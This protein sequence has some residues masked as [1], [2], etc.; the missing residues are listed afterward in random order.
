MQQS[1]S[2][3]LALLSVNLL[4]WHQSIHARHALRREG[5]AHW[6]RQLPLCMHK[7]D[8]LTCNGTF[9]SLATKEAW[10]CD[11]LSPIFFFSFASS[12]STAEALMMALSD[13]DE[14]GGGGRGEEGV[15]GLYCVWVCDLD[16]PSFLTSLPLLL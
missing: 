5:R 12:S 3:R 1:Q 2:A 6:F 10:R 8:A 14:Y 16:E 13:L 9:A 4:R 15:G 7:L 11:H